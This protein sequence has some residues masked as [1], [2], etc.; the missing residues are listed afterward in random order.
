MD[1]I[2]FLIES[3]Q[4]LNLSKGRE[5][6]RVLVFS[7]QEGKILISSKHA[8]AIRFDSETKSSL[9]IGSLLSKGPHIMCIS[10][11]TVASAFSLFNPMSTVTVVMLSM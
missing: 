6:F 5:I 4:A 2:I 8:S 7:V 1:F 11:R 3:D 10:S 9:L